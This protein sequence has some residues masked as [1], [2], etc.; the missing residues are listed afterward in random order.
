MTHVYPDQI[1]R[2]HTFPYH[3]TATQSHSFVDVDWGGDQ[4]HQRSVTSIMD[5]LSGGVT[6]Y[7]TKFQSALF[8][9]STEAEFTAVANAQ[10]IALYLRSILKAL[11]FEQHKLMLIYEDNILGAL[12]TIATVDQPTKRTCHMDTKLFVL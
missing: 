3:A 4:S 1:L 7:I 5:M 10:K 6:A 9:S 8:L 11:E 2:T 12:F